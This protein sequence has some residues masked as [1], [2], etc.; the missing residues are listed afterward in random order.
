MGFVIKVI[1]KHRY[2]RK[3]VPKT[4]VLFKKKSLRVLIPKA[5][6]MWTEIIEMAAGCGI[7]EAT[8]RLCVLTMTQI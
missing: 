8:Y 1:S 2:I 7:L 3:K 6:N 5:W 4:P